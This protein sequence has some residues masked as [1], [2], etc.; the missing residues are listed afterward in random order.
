MKILRYLFGFKLYHAVASEPEWMTILMKLNN[1]TKLREP[2][3]PFS[4]I[5]NRIFWRLELWT[6]EWR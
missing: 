3:F 2:I 5:P 4:D 1:D 6:R